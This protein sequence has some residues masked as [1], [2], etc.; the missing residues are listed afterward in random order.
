MF[1]IGAIPPPCAV[2][3]ETVFV[4]CVNVTSEVKVGVTS[5]TPESFVNVTIFLAITQRTTKR[6]VEVS[7][8]E[9]PSFRRTTLKLKLVIS[10]AGHPDI[11]SQ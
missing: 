1:L 9:V 10:V 4:A 2:G 11:Q 5:A 8:V 6:Y 3:G 7:A